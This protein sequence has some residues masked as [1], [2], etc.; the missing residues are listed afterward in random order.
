MPTYTWAC[1]K[2]ATEK[3]VIRKMTE[4][5]LAPDEACQCGHNEFERLIQSSR[6]I[7]KG[8]GWHRDEYTSYGPDYNK[9]KQSHS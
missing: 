9:Q 5:H 4:H 3:D 7:L 2:C 6:F 8:G 1:K